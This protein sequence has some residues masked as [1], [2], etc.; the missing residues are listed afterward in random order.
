MSQVALEDFPYDLKDYRYVLIGTMAIIVTYL[1]TIYVFTMATRIRIFN[2]KFMS[3]FDEL[4]SKE[5]KQGAKAPQFGY[6]D[7]GSGWFSKHLPYKQWYELNNAQRCQLNFLEQLPII[8]ISGLI[9]GMRFTMLTFYIQL[10][11]CVGRMIYNMGYMIGPSKRVVGAIMMD[12]AVV[13][14]FV[15]AYMTLYKLLWL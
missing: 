5:V 6:P 9:S 8:L 2:K 4:H 15:M 10:G 12:I 14:L 7:N 3:Q 11:Y 13:A 1:T